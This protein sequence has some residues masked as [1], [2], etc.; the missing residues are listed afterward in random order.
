MTTGRWYRTRRKETNKYHP[1]IFFTTLLVP[2]D[3]STQ[4]QSAILK[5]V[6]LA[7][8]Y[9]T[10]SKSN[11]HRDFFPHENI[12]IVR[13]RETP[14]QFVKLSWRETR[15][16]SFLFRRFIRIG[17]IASLG[18]RS[19]LLAYACLFTQVRRQAVTAPAVVFNIWRSMV[20]PFELVTQVLRP[21][22]EGNC[23]DYRKGFR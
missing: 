20:V 1:L 13:F 8:L 10:F 23:L 12:R 4:V 16:M 19:V 3:Q 17:G 7:Y 22:K 14:L 5:Q 9:S 6:M 18:V 21:W 11:P 15:P 2:F